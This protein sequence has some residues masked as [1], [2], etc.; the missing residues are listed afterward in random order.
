MAFGKAFHLAMEYYDLFQNTYDIAPEF[1]GVRGNTKAQQLEKWTNETGKLPLSNDEMIRINLMRKRICENEDFENLFKDS[2][3]EITIFAKDPTTNLL[4]KGK[5]DLLKYDHEFDGFVIGD[6]KTCQPLFLSNEK[7]IQSDILYGPSR[8]F[9]QYSFY[10]FL[11]QCLG[12]NSEFHFLFIEKELPF[13][14]RIVHLDMDFYSHGLEKIFTELYDFSECQKLDYWP[15][16]ETNL[17]ITF[18]QYLK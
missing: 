12:F 18:P 7:K 9:Y 14:F 13:G 5:V 17:T 1:K 11:F 10:R 4:L 6:Y 8:M 16:Y 15:D 2:M 3:N